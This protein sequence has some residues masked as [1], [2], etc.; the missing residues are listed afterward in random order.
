E[1]SNLQRQIIHSTERLGVKKVDSA[2]KSIE[3]LNPDVKVV[4]YDEMLLADKVER[5]IAGYDVILD[6]TDTFETR[7][8]LN[9]AAVAAGIPVAHAAAFRVDGQLSTLVL[10]AGT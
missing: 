5:L 3:A 9:D 7:Y 8:L 6:G 10:Y 4:T 1:G 2:R